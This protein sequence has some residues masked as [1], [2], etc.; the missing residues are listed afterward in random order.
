MKVTRGLV[1]VS[2]QIP[3]SP[4]WL[5]LNKILGSSNSSRRLARKASR[6]YVT[7]KPSRIRRTKRAQGPRKLPLRQLKL[8][9]TGISTSLLL[10]DFQDF[11]D[12]YE[13]HDGAV[14]MAGGGVEKSL[15]STSLLSL[16]S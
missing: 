2:T 3:W 7:H 13:L 4:C 16:F 15:S 10:G 6:E 9:L 12:T 8:G 5:K 14:F 11:S 1:D